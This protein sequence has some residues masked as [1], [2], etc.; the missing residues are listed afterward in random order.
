M[1]HGLIPIPPEEEEHLWI[2]P[3]WKWLYWAV[4]LYTILLILLLYILTVG[5]DHHVQ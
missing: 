3:N 4:A 5:L 2:L 1:R